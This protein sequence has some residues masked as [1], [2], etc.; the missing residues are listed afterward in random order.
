MPDIKTL[1]SLESIG[2]KDDP[3]VSQDELLRQNFND[4]VK[5]ENGRYNVTWPWKEDCSLLPENYAL[6]RGRLNSLVKRLKHEPELLHKYNDVI[7]DQLKREIIEPVHQNQT[8]G[9]KHY[10]PHHPVVTPGHTTTKLRIVYDGSAKAKKED[11]S[12]NECLHR[13][14]ILLEDLTG[15]LMRFQLNRI[16]IL[17][18]IEKAFLQV[19]LQN[20]DRDATRF[21]WLKDPENCDTEGNVQ[22][23]RFTRIPFGV[24]SSPFLLGATISHHLKQRNNDAA[25]KLQADMYVDNVVTGTNDLD[26]AT[27]FYI[28]AKENFQS[29]SMNLREW[30][31]NSQEFMNTIP[32]ED[33]STQNIVKV[34]GLQWDTKSDT[35]RVNGSQ[36]LSSLVVTT[37]REV[38]QV[39]G[40]IFD[41][42]GYFSPCTLA[43]KVF[44]QDLWDKNVEWDAKLTDEQLRKWKHIVK[45]TEPISSIAFNRFKGIHEGTSDAQHYELIA[46]CDASKIAY[47]TA[48]YL[49]VSTKSETTVN[50]IF[51]KSRL[52]PKRV[53]TI[54]R[55]ELMAVVIA[56]R[57]LN[58]VKRML[59]IQLKKIMLFTDSQC[60]LKWI[61]TKKTLSVFVENRVREIRSHEDIEFRYVPT[62]DNPADIAT[63]GKTAKELVT[64]TIW[65]KGPPWLPKIEDWPEWKINETDNAHDSFNDE[66]RCSKRLYETSMIIGEEDTTQC[67]RRL[68]SKPF[69]LNEHNFSSLHRLLRVTAWC[70]RFVNATRKRDIVKGP[71]SA[72][73]LN[74][75]KLK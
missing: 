29:A 55:L 18:D 65:W 57:C 59:K 5:L 72:K 19:G 4:T 49:K 6:A 28:D 2:I 70:I 35:L 22:V 68:S 16:G 63:R 73:E 20:C 15:L 42:L 13:G 52:A 9:P 26:E 58:F 31:S 36:A 67:P 14:L 30:T 8:D 21:L 10:I 39:I 54:P 47:A 60:V 62:K 69:E 75:A 40:R 12:L 51:A 61:F 64:T 41:P 66:I 71:L 74:F 7:Q 24:I 25:T 46:F 3:Q 11:K 34:L 38:V 33:R 43:A 56:L 1:W 27:R 50:L 48:I 53:L 17:A 45:E 23:Y 44:L 32:Q 37:K